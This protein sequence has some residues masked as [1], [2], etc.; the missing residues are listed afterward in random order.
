VDLNDPGPDGICGTGDDVFIA[1]DVTDANGSYLFTGL[2]QGTYCVDPDETTVPAGYVL[3]TN[4]DPQTV[5][6]GPGEDFLDADFG[7]THLTCGLA[8]SKLCLATSAPETQPPSDSCEIALGPT[9]SEVTYIYEVTNLGDSLSGVTL[10]DDPLGHIAGPFSLATG[11]TRTFQTVVEIDETVT[12][13][14]T[15]SGFLSNG[16]LCSASDTATVTVVE[17]PNQPPTADPNGPYVGAVGSA[18]VFDGAAS[19]DPD[20]D[21]LT[22]AWDFG[23]GD[24]AT[25]A[26]P[27]HTYSDAGIYD[28]CLTVNDGYVDSEEACTIA[29]IYDPSAGF[30]TG[31]GWIDSPEGAYVPD[32]TLVGKATF[33]FVS[34]YKKGATVPTG[35][36]EFQFK[37]ADLNFHSSSY[38]WLVVTGSDYARFK[39]SGTINGEGEYKFML[40]AGDGTGTNG[41]DTFR[42]NIWEEDEETAA[43]TVIYDN[44]S[45][46]EVGGGS[47][48]VHTK[49][50]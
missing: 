6:L 11:E 33:G 14:G 24:M 45:N 34:K 37:T 3:T 50:K 26:T 35:N 49:D 7:F 44:G 10:F 17:P 25:G 2:P 30:V 42:I 48:V 40:W 31:G 18:I 13:V 21:P 29:V 19:S 12:N 39:G 38:D 20:N 41:A 16:A 23:D 1:S 36:T 47:I 4:N 9:P 32:P 27:S 46:Q 28:V 5:N 22:Y 15:F 43:E 8:V